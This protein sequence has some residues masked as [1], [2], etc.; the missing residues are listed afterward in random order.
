VAC[1][2]GKKTLARAAE[3]RPKRAVAVCRHCPPVRSG[4][5]SITNPD[6]TR[7]CSRV[8]VFDMWIADVGQTHLWLVGCAHRKVRE[9]GGSSSSG[10][11]AALASC[12]GKTQRPQ[13]RTGARCFR[14]SRGYPGLETS[15]RGSR[16]RGVL[17]TTKGVPGREQHRLL[18][19]AVS[20]RPW[21]SGS[22]AESAPPH[23]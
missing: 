14:I 12:R 19:R 11:E 5:P 1:P 7:N 22:T 8:L 3:Q 2:S 18:N 9:D 21:F 23:D 15:I 20:A 17:G 13:E 10:T 6:T 16:F 4:A